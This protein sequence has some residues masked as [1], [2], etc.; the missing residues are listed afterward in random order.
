MSK[1]YGGHI[2]ARYLKEV[3]DIDTI[4][5]LSGGHIDRIYDGAVEYDLRLIDVRHEQAAVMM[6]HSWSICQQKPGV[7]L[8]TAGPGFTNAITGIVNAKLE[9]APVVI[10]CGT[11]PRRD[12]D[13]G[14][15]QDI[16]QKTMIDSA[17]KMSITCHDI[18]RIPEYLSMAFRV[19]TSGRPGPVFLELIPDILNISIDEAELSESIPG[20]TSYQFSPEP[21]DIKNAAKM[22]NAAK[23]P[24]IIG[25][26]G[27]RGCEQE[28]DELVTKTGSPFILLNSGRGT[29]PDSNPLSMWRGGLMSIMVAMS[30]ADLVIVLGTRLDWVLLNG[31]GFP[32]AKVV[33]VDIEPTEINRNRQSDIGLVGDM[34]PTLKSLNPS[35]ERK[36]RSAW[37]QGLQEAYL[38]MVQE[39]VD[40]KN[41][42][43]DPIHPLHLVHKTAKTIGNDALYYADGGDSCYFG[44]IGTEASEGAS[45][46][47]PAGGLFG[48]L[49]T[50]IPFGLGA[51]AARPDKQVIVFSGDGSFGLNAMEFNTA[52]R[53]NLP[54]ICIVIN[55][56]SW[57]M[58]KHG[59]ALTYGEDRIIGSELGIVH[60]E[61]MAESL[62]GYGEL[63]EKEKDIVPAIKRAL[64][65]KKPACI[66]VL[67]DTSVTSPATYSF[68]ESLKME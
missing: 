44:L 33:R 67:T 13:M 34:K 22:I 28:L 59:Q 6:A 41:K 32:Q 31:K 19:A 64:E 47:G 46:L 9:N 55:D 68:V 17:V 10:L 62:G 66:N 35:I 29:I 3:E 8:V 25:G 26:S 51:K 1:I 63:V 45:V 21:P 48:C 42:E 38:P 4:F 11:S 50:G 7:C 16:D 60:Y 2:V 56:Q 36:D 65:S 20:T 37:V 15:L 61:K 43:T 23:N 57:G 27:C 14:A 52:V 54:F 53:H 5:S 12:W 24:F 40:A 49:G 18:S 39:E 30:M 58:I